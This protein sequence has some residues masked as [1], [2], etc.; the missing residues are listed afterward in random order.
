VVDSRVKEEMESSG[1]NGSGNVVLS[2]YSTDGEGRAR[3]DLFIPGSYVKLYM[4]EAIALV[5]ALVRHM[6]V[7]E[8]FESGEDDEEDFG[9]P[10]PTIH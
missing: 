6:E 7:I 8:E 2:G 10:S 3:I 1:S 5:A 9:E 4:D